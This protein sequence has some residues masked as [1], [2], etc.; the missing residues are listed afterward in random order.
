MT[1]MID[2]DGERPSDPVT[3]D[4]PVENGFRSM[5]KRL[6][7]KD[8]HSDKNIGCARAHPGLDGDTMSAELHV[9]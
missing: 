1:T 8:G 3:R 2:D 4:R 6:S 5:M 9:Q 7:A